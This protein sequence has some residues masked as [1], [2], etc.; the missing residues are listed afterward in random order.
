M[1]RPALKLLVKVLVSLGL[2]AFLLSQLELTEFFITLRSAHVSYLIIALVAY[3]VGQALSSLR[4]ALLAWPLGFRNPMKDFAIYYFIGM[5]FNLFAP[6][7]VGG[8]VSR[9]YYLAQQKVYGRGD[10]G[11]T[12]PAAYAVV[13]VVTDR[14]IGMTV[15]VWIGAVAVA[16]F[17]GY[18]IPSP[19]RYTVYSLALGLLLA[20]MLVPNA[21]RFIQRAEHSWGRKLALIVKSYQGSWQFLIQAALISL[22]VHTIQAGMQLLVGWSLDVELPWSYCFILYPLVGTF[23]AL[24][25]SLNGIGLREGGYLFLLG[26]VGVS[27]E[28]GVAFGLLWLLIV[29]LDSLIGGILFVLKGR[30]TDDVA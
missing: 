19:I 2:V 20:G 25:F 26:H 17:P 12:G 30:E 7:T 18:A 14:A 3:L 22:L 11:W 13:S 16:L 4:W 28:K 29:A 23:S 8:D 10:G 24:P 15:L 1:S 21:V 27:S 5:F 9:A 6:S